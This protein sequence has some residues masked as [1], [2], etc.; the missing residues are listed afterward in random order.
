MHTSPKTGKVWHLVPEAV[1]PNDEVFACA[2]C[3]TAVKISCDKGKWEAKTR[4]NSPRDDF[5][6]FDDLYDDNG[7]VPPRS[8]ARG[9]DFG[10]LS[11]LRALGIETSLSTLET[12]LLAEA[13]A[14]SVIE[15]VEADPLRSKLK[16]QVAIFCQ[17]P[18]ELPNEPFG[19]TA[20]KAAL[21]QVRVAFVGPAGVK[22]RYEREA[23]KILDNRL[24]PEVIFNALTWRHALTRPVLADG[25]C[26]D[27]APPPDI[28]FIE[29]LLDGDARLSQHIEET[30]LVIDEDL[31]KAVGRGRRACRRSVRG[32]GRGRRRRRRR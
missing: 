18:E 10:R 21:G 1:G 27:T 29:R 6:P 14:Y 4:A 25:T 7:H 9:C 16:G 19:E 12:L 5:D 15:K 11:A 2:R 22:T 30:G 28:D 24:R 13:R 8:V 17:V 20:L 26:R 23:L 3:N 31:D 32:P